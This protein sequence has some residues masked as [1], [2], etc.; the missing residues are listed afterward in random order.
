MKTPQQ[1]VFITA[2]NTLKRRAQRGPGMSIEEMQQAADQIL[3]EH[4]AKI[5]EDTLSL[6][7]ETKETITAWKNGTDNT[8]LIQKLTVMAQAAEDQG[9]V[10]G[11]P[12]LTEVGKRLNAFTFLFA[13]S[14]AHS[15]PN[16][17]AIVAIELHLDAMMVAIDPR[18]SASIEDS[19]LV[20]LQ[21]LELTQRTVA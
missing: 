19:G 21:N 8:I 4:A 12:L 14:M 13:K 18:Q 11:N 10:I 15:V 6:I 9:T 2:M 16:Q 5:R 7:V 3:L 17:K 1:P 20:L